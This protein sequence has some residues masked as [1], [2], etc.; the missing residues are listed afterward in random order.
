MKAQQFIIFP[1]ILLASIAMAG[2]LMVLSCNKEETR[3]IDNIDPQNL[4]IWR[5]VIDRDTVIAECNPM[6]S[7]YRLSV[8]HHDWTLLFNDGTR[9]HYSIEDSILHLYDIYGNPSFPLDFVMQRISK[10]SV[11][12]SV[13]GYVI[14]DASL[15]TEYLFIKQ[16]TP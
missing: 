11:H 3:P 10:D 8:V 13:H 7:S 5:S 14:D 16:D 15:I 4:Q 12:L 9:G 6:D 1:R 2:S